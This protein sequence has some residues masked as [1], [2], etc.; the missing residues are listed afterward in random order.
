[1]ARRRYVEAERQVRLAELAARAARA[2]RGLLRLGDDAARRPPRRHPAEPA[3]DGAPHALGIDVAGH[4]ERQV[5]GDVVAAEE[6]DQLALADPAHRLGGADHRP[7]VRVRGVRGGE[8]AL[9]H[10]ARGIVAALPDL[11]EHDLALARELLGID[12][13]RGQRVA[14]RVDRGVEVIRAEDRVIHGV[15]ERGPRVDLAAA[16]LDRADQLAHAVVGRA[17]EQHVLEQVRD[18]GLA[19]RLIRRTDADP[20]LHRRHRRRVLGCDMQGEAVLEA[21]SDDV[22]HGGVGRGARQD[23]EQRGGGRIIGTVCD[24]GHLLSQ[25]RGLSHSAARRGSFRA[26]G[27]AILAA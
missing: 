24:A 18:P 17:L 11:L 25:L 7:A 27:R 23:T 10:R 15:I 1:V 4:D 16:A 21:V 14:E 3:Q 19:R 22:V 9:R 2:R 5:V 8:Q 13:R 20:R 6:V 12:A 26:P